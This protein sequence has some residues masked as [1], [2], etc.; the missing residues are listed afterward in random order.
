[1]VQD[2]LL[3]HYQHLADIS[4]AMLAA[5]RAREW[6]QLLVLEQQ[7]AYER[8]AGSPPCE[9]A[10]APPEQQR[11]QYQVALTRCIGNHQLI[12]AL[13][14]TWMTQLSGALNSNG[15]EQ[16]LAAAYGPSA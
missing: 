5:A 15:I 13:T 14:L 6:D 11:M 16:R 7:V 9:A 10:S 3:L 12:R 2:R 1:M 4:D 8:V